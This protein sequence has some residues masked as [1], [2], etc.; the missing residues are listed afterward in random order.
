MVSMDP[1][2]QLHPAARAMAAPQPS[3]RL[4][5]AAPEVAEL[6]P[7]LA[8]WALPACEALVLTKSLSGF[9]PAVLD[10]CRGIVND[11]AS[12]RRPP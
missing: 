8:G 2:V 7:G 9:T 3:L 4:V 12:G 6:A 5:P 1:D 10:A 11:I